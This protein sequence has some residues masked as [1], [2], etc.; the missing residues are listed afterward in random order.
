M[1]NHSVKPLVLALIASFAVAQVALAETAPR[2]REDVS[3]TPGRSVTPADESVISSSAS[4]VMHH[5][6]RARDALRK[7]NAE[8]AK[9]ELRQA[10]TLLDIIQDN[11]PTSIIK[12]QVWTADNK[13]KYENT[14]EI[15]ASVV[16]IYASL[17]ERADFDRVKLPGKPAAKE[18]AKEA[19][20]A[21]KDTKDAKADVKAPKPA[22]REEAE[23]RDAVLY[24]EEVDM[25]LNAVRHFVS[26]A[27]TE[28]SKGNINEAD[29]NLRAALD[30][31]DYTSLYLPAPLLA[32][33]INLERAQAHFDA[34]RV[35]QAHADV[36][37]AISQLE[38][39]N[40]QADADSKADVDKLLADAKS[41]ETRIDKSEPGLAA[42]LKGL[43]RRAEAQTE[44]AMEATSI[45]WAKLRQTDKLR[46]AL[47]E[48][49]R[50]VAY[51]DI[52]ANVAGDAKQAMS[53]LE[54]ARSWLEKAA[55]SD[56]GK[57]GEAV[58]VKD[59]RAVVDTLLS[60]QATPGKG[61]MANLKQQLTQAISQS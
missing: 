12:N 25:P 29:K 54:K 48:A 30:S 11:V 61:E 31:V 44:R 43:W 53:E 19:N 18:A 20:P 4:M 60:G 41:L 7:N 22:T 32:A 21:E 55:Q 59:I 42:E 56:A 46:N 35:P 14:E 28:L 40:N 6:V 52:D 13:L 51:A 27:Q 38:R 33:R 9:T 8:L 1:K 39:A 36:T 57:N 17:E 47:I 58:Y 50:H 2:L 5:V 45:G 26:T 10:D 23:A 3:V 16:P 49:K 24:Y 37:R 34:G 15:P